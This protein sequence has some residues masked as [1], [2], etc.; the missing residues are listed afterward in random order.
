MILLSDNFRQTLPV[1]PRL[2]AANELNACLKSS[3]L[4]SC[5]KKL[6]LTTNMRVALLNDLSAEDFFKKLLTIS[7]G[8]VPVN[9]SSRLIS[10]PWNFCS[11]V[12]SK[13][14]HHS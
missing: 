7:N 4:C 11:F 2:T 12:S 9:K 8:C 10:F 6:Q 13:D 3:N 14:E 5:V 1:I